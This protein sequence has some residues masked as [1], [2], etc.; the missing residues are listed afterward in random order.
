ML[1]R[2]YL[3][4]LHLHPNDTVIDVGCG[5]G[6]IVCVC[7]RRHI[8]KA[9]GVEISP[10]LADRARENARR[11][12]GRRAPVE[13]L[14]ADAT[15]ADYAE[16]TAFVMFNPFGAATM[17]VVLERIRQTLDASPRRLRVAYLNPREEGVFR[18]CGWLHRYGES[19]SPF[20]RTAATYWTNDPAWATGLG[21]TPRHGG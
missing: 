10:E 6:R 9:I 21:Y 8:A 12:R 14:T 3:K 2:Q 15:R 4:P 11:L 16:G 1:I 13:I 5:L 20:Y 19:H 17:S 18:S 7:A